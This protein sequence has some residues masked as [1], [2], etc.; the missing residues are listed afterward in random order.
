[1]QFIYCRMGVGPHP[2]YIGGEAN[3]ID[4]LR[5]LCIK[6]LI[7]QEFGTVAGVVV[8]RALINENAAY[9]HTRHTYV[10][11]QA[12]EAVRD[13]FYVQKLSWKRQIHASNE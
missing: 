6:L 10:H 11:R 3:C 8:L 13:A 4:H 9:W 5:R 12:R 2:A 7:T 1:M